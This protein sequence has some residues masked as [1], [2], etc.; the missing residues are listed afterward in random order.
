MTPFFISSLMTST[1]DMVRRS[2]SSLTLRARGITT[3]RLASPAGA[4][5]TLASVEASAGQPCERPEPAVTCRLML[6][7]LA[8]HGTPSLSRSR[9]P[10]RLGQ[11]GGEG[12]QAP[13]SPPSACAKRLRDAVPL[14]GLFPA[15]CP[16]A[17]IGAAPRL[18]ACRVNLH[19]PRREAD[20]AHQ[21]SLGGRRPAGD[22][23]PLRQTS[24]R[25]LRLSAH[26][27]PAGPRALELL[28]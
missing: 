15:R 22:A 2:A 1:G 20:N 18:L 27:G 6:L 4:V 7:P 24:G 5:A 26:Q 28:L 13:C 11:G 19:H 21:F 8:S 25:R 9:R 3:L 10:V 17:K 14:H 12:P 23:T 16:T